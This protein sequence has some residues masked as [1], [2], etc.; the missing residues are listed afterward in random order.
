MNSIQ[1]LYLHP[2]MFRENSGH[3]LD[4]SEPTTTF[5]SNI[6]DAICSPPIGPWYIYSLSAIAVKIKNEI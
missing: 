5:R 2:W 1:E 4:K 6:S 3:I